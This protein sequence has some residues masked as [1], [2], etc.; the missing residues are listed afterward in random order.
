MASDGYYLTVF[1]T[2]NEVCSHSAELWWLYL[3]RCSAC[4]QYWMVAQDDR[5]Y[6]DFVL[7]RLDP[8]AADGIIKTGIWPPDFLT[9]ERVLALGSTKSTP[10]QFLETF[11]SSLQSSVDDLRKARPTN[12]PS[13]IARL[14]G[15]TRAH[16]RLLYWKGRLFGVD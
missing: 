14:L 5:T 7:K 16:A 15:I 8:D 4:G 6:D 10:P 2:L 9:Y 1:A 13:E 11:A 3:S 12:A